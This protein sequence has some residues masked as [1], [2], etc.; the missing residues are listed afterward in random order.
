LE[1]IE[2]EKWVREYPEN[3]PDEWFFKLKGQ[4]V[5]FCDWGWYLMDISS[6][7]WRE[8]WAGEVL[9]Q[10]RTNAADGIFVDS[11]FPPNYYGGDK[12][13]PNLPDLDRTFE[14]TW[15]TQIEDFIAF[16]QS[17]DL[18][19][20]Y[21]IPNAGEWVNGRDVTDY[22]GADGIMVE[23]FGRWSYGEYFLAQEGDWQL[24]M[25]R[26]LS[27]VNLDKIVLLQQYVNKD[28]M[29]DRLFLLGSYLL[30]K[31]HHTYLNFELSS[32]P[33]WFPEYEIPIGTPV[34][35]IPPSIST[36]WRSDWELYTRTYSN[37]LVLVNPSDKLQEVV[38]QKIYYQAFPYGGGIVPSDGDV[39]DW[40]VD[41]VPVTNIS[42][43]PNE[44]VIL[45]DMLPEQ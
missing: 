16:G 2:G 45:L 27:M 37:G 22:S 39:S 7:S 5:L 21:F 9:R 33:E 1:V 20:Y 26:V 13:D 3:P 30:V 36:M 34:G 38:F 24:Q 10:L 42:L 18:A 41:Y 17:G 32:E 44:A 19:D 6:A 12:F 4:R 14:K 8:Y 31:G 28:D 35:G 15:S 11:L 25:D 43:G 23:G 29:E 40:V